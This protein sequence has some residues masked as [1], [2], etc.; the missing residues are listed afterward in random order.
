MVIQF[1][2]PATDGCAPCCAPA[3][4]PLDTLLDLTLTDI[5]LCGCA[6]FE[7]ER[8]D[9]VSDPADLLGVWEDIPLGSLTTITTAMLQKY[10]DDCVTPDG[11]PVETDV[12]VLINCANGYYSIVQIQIG[13]FNIFFSDGNYM[14]DETIPN[15]QECIGSTTFNV[16]L[17]IGSA[18]ISM[19]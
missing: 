2:I 11:D 16:P 14:L 4:V 17:I 3:C 9:I 12:Q 5:T 19:P 8:S 15:A 6:V 13:P 7:G 18:E 10:S 1:S